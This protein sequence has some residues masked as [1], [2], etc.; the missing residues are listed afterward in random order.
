MT[1]CIHTS[2]LIAN[3]DGFSE[4]SYND[5]LTKE[6][7]AGMITDY[8]A[9]LTKTVTEKIEVIL[10]TLGG[11]T[12]YKCCKAINTNELRLMDEVAPAISLCSDENGRW[13][14]TKSGNLGNTRTLIE[15]LDYF[16]HHE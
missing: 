6:K 14:V 11:E 3:F 1:V 7:L 13:I 16:K 2:N 10:I 9:E 12:S 5:E 15:I 8:L 4:D